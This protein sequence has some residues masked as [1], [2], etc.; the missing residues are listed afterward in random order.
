MSE[1]AGSST[2]G[3]VCKDSDAPVLYQQIAIYMA[4]LEQ[5]LERAFAKTVN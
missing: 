4:L 2:A 5:H 1:E 3:A